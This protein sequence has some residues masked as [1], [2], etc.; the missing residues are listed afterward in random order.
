[1]MCGRPAIVTDVGGNR[2]VVEHGK[3]G[4]LAAPAE[5]TLEEA[6]AAREMLWKI[7]CRAAARIRELVPPDPA[8]DFAT[9]LLDMVGTGGLKSP[10]KIQTLN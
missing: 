3:T 8:R 7:G 9:V 1:M 5:D 6:W 10:E 2:E 4:F